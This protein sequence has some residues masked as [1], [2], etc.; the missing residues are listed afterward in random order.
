MGA[1]LPTP[2]ASDGTRGGLTM[3]RGN[4]N[5]RGAALLLPTPTASVATKSIRTM[6][7]AQDELDRGK[8]ADIA[9]LAM[10]LPT[11]TA[12]AYGSNQSPSAGAAVHPSLSGLAKLLPTPT[13]QDASNN[14]APSHVNAVAGGSLNPEW[15]EWL[16][17]FPIGWTDCAA[18]ETP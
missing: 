14:G 8:G 2:T 6:Q 1:L 5:L 15:V 16:Q 12:S 18:S 10:L 11:P 17:G 9:V 7:G 3:Q 4:P 13:T